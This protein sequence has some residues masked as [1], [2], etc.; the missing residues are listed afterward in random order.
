MIKNVKGIKV[1][2]CFDIQIVDQ[3]IA[4]VNDIKMD[5]L[6]TESNIFKKQIIS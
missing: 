6:I 5:Y 1:G 3:V 4:D 2:I